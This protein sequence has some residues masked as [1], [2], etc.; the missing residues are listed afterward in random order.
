MSAIFSLSSYDL[1][2]LGLPRAAVALGGFIVPLFVYWA[3]PRNRPKRLYMMV[4]VPAFVWQFAYAWMIQANTEAVA[5][6]WSGIGRMAT[7]F[8]P[9][10]VYAFG[11]WHTEA[12]RQYP[13]VGFGF[14]V[15]AVMSAFVYHPAL[16]SHMHH[17]AWG[18]YGVHGPWH[19]AQLLF[20]GVAVFGLYF[21]LLKDFRT[22]RSQNQRKLDW[23]FM[24]A[25][26]GAFIFGALEFLPGYGIDVRPVGFLGVSFWSLIMLW[27]TL[28]YQRANL[29]NLIV[30]TYSYLGVSS[31]VFVMYVCLVALAKWI[32]FGSVAWSELLFA[33]CALL[34]IFPLADSLRRQIQSA[35]ARFYHRHRLTDHATLSHF[36]EHLKEL[37]NSKLLLNDLATVLKQTTGVTHAAVFLRSDDRQ[38]YILGDAHGAGSAPLGVAAQHPVMEWLKARDLVLSR[39]ALVHDAEFPE[40]RWPAVSLMDDL[41][42][43]HLIPMPIAGDLIGFLALG[44]RV[45]GVPFDVSDLQLLRIVGK[46]AA[47]AVS[48]A[49]LFEEVTQKNLAL[50][51]VD[52]E[53]ANFLANTSHELRTPLHG[54]MGIAEAML[55]GA[56][57]DM[58]AKQAFHVQMIHESGKA[59]AELVEK[60]LDLQRLESNRVDFEISQFGMADIAASV[61]PII[62]GVLNKNKRAVTLEVD[63]RDLPPVHGDIRLVS[64]VLV[65]LMGNAAKFTESGSIRLTGWLGSGLKGAGDV[66]RDPDHFVT[67]AVID[68]GIGLRAEDCEVIFQ[69]FRQ[70]DGSVKR[71][72]GGTGLGLAIVKKIIEAHG[73]VI[74]VDS[75]LG[76]GSTFYFSLPR[77]AFTLE[78]PKATTREAGH[79]RQSSAVHPLT[80]DRVYAVA[81]PEQRQSLVKGEGETVLVIDDNPVNVEII[82]S[83]LE[84]DGYRVEAS[85]DPVEGWKML[86]TRKPDLVILDVMMP[87]TSGYEFCQKMRA[88]AEMQRIPVIMVTAKSTTED[89]VYGLS[90]G[91]DDYLSK[92]FHKEELVARVNTLTRIKRIQDRLE[93]AYSELKAINDLSSVINRELELDRL[94]VATLDRV[95][96]LVKADRGAIFTIEQGTSEISLR[97]SKGFSSNRRTDVLKEISPEILRAAVTQK[98][99]EVILDLAQ[100][101]SEK[102]PSEAL[103]SVICLPLALHDKSYGALYLYAERANALTADWLRV[104]TPLAQQISVSMHNAY[105]Y[106]LAVTDDL[107]RLYLKRHFMELLKHELERATKQK[108]VFSVVMIDIDHFKRFNDTYG[109][110]LGDELLVQVAEILLDSC[111]TS[112]V[113]ARFGGE[114]F[115]VLLRDT[116]LDEA[117]VFAQRYRQA[118]EAYHHYHRGE[119]LKITVSAGVCTFEPGVS[120]TLEQMLSAVDAELYHSKAAGRNRVSA[121]KLGKNQPPVALHPSPEPLL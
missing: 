87:L 29:E 93:R 121:R 24:V 15:S 54:I 25:F 46:N 78:T 67:F 120:L 103:G 82:R 97:F 34:V 61:V 106:D 21:N 79:A 83:C 86:E 51:Q 100:E 84:A 92:P 108:S 88:H 68:S 27:A 64:Q 113:A 62:E 10:V 74:G 117:A 85:L 30:G 96:D 3:D 6:F 16:F 33:A 119:A 37:T 72:F 90:I 23:F 56:D 89:K 49:L 95:V 57:G 40:I 107:T 5:L 39:D 22:T 69:R 60:L 70:A 59:L 112:D 32:L 45:N 9:A 28:R 73:G 65:N 36:S 111:R 11:V 118:V 58:N 81:K 53:K 94:L 91:A 47:V 116:D 43:A 14:L 102:R 13:L 55:D 12:R 52:K 76:V 77:H 99:P 44:K 20:T 115:M 63:L 1:S 42:V 48:N 98:Q 8:I 110:P 80:S 104:L 101:R 4:V 38:S 18:Y 19:R 35:I 7:Y 50:I 75:T 41:G 31:A 2:L 26:A 66:A 114:E 105:L 71:R 109:H 17:Y